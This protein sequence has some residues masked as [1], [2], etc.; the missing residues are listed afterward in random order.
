MPE[1]KVLMAASRHALVTIDG[2]YLV[3]SVARTP[4]VG[5]QYDYDLDDVK[6]NSPLLYQAEAVFDR[7]VDPAQNR[8]MLKLKVAINRSLRLGMKEWLTGPDAESD[9]WLVQADGGEF[10][11]APL[12]EDNDLILL[13]QGDSKNYRFKVKVALELVGAEDVEQEN[14]E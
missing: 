9:E 4:D 3:V 1:A 14:G 13:A 8:A 5:G 6:Y 2:H 12:W 10:A 7:L 11:V